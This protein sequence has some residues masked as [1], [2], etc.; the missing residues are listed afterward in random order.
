MDKS[1]F[2]LNIKIIILKIIIK[3]IIVNIKTIKFTE[4]IFVNK[5]EKCGPT[6]D[7]AFINHTSPLLPPPAASRH[8]PPPS[9]LPPAPGSGNNGTQDHRAFSDAKGPVVGPPL[10][11]RRG[12]IPPRLHG[13]LSTPQFQVGSPS[14]AS[15]LSFSFGYGSCACFLVPPPSVLAVVAANGADCGNCVDLGAVGVGGR[16]C[17]FNFILLLI[18][19]TSRS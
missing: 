15:S 3:Y 10:L 1:M 16:F 2:F 19:W 4:G 7:V 9:P 14:A 18:D 12:Q 17:Y 6:L 5:Q 11:S 13:L 8:L